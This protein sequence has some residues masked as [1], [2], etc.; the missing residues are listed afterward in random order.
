MDG[1][2][3][4]RTF[5]VIKRIVPQH[6]A[7]VVPKHDRKLFGDALCSELACPIT[8]VQ[9]T[10]VWT[11]LLLGKTVGRSWLGLGSFGWLLEGSWAVLGGCWRP[12][13]LLLRHLGGPWANLFTFE[14]LTPDARS[15]GA[16]FRS[17][18]GSQ[19]GAKMQPK[20]DQ[21]RRQKRR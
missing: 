4:I 15:V 20:R 12:L 3:C 13:G 6:N 10:C 11:M 2:R 9:N 17:P 19:D 16:I 21:N 1:K 5:Y 18:R 14:G 7:R 8:T